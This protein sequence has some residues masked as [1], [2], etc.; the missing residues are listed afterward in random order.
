MKK[1]KLLLFVLLSIALTA[2]DSSE[3]TLKKFDV[4]KI[5]FKITDQFESSSAI[6]YTI[7]VTNNTEVLISH[8]NLYLSFSIKIVNGTMLLIQNIHQ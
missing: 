8:L 7:K 2:C 4:D 1:L 5:S 6:S 3:E